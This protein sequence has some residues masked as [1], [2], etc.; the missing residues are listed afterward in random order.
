MHTF[1]ITIQRQSD[2][3]YPVIAEEHQDGGQLPIRV[4]G[5]L[6][7]DQSELL[8]AEIDRVGYGKLL[9]AA[10]F[11]GDVRDGFVE[12]LA[13]A[14]DLLR[15]LLFIEDVPMRAVR[16]ER[17]Y[18]PIDG[19]WKLLATLQRAPFSRYMPSLTDRRFPPIGRRDLRALIVAASPAPDNRFQLEPFDVTAATA[20]VREALGPIPSTLLA[21]IDGADGRPTLDEICAR[22]TA[23]PHTILHLVCHGRVLKDGESVLY[24]AGDA[25]PGTVEPVTGTRLLERL[26]SLEGARGLPHFAFLSTCE[27]ASPD[28][29]EAMGGLG[30][31]LVRELGMPAVVAMTDKVSILTANALSAAIYARLREHGEPDRALVE[32]SVRL[33][34][35]GDVMVPVLF[36]RLGGQPLFSDTLDRALTAAEMAA[37]LDSL[38]SC[39]PVRAPVLADEFGS[40]AAGLRRTLATRPELM[41]DQVRHQQAEALAMIE[42][43]CGEA[44][45]ISFQ[46]LCL[47]QELPPYDARCPFPGLRAFQAD[48]RDFFF[49]REPLVARLLARVADSPFL[50]VL[51]PSGSGKSSAVFAGLVPALQARRPELPLLTM[52]PGE[53]PLASLLA[54]LEQAGPAPTS[55]G[56]PPV[57]RAILVIDQFEEV[58]TL[59]QDADE[60][61]EFF[62]E[63]LRQVGPL[64]VI[65]TLRADFL[66]EVAPYPTL[67]EM[68]TAHQELIAPMTPEELRRAMERQAAA[69]GLRFEA[70]LGGQILDDVRGEP[71]AMPLLQH[72]LQELWA[73]RR[74][75]W[76]RGAEYRAIGGIQQA[77]AH[78]ADQIFDKAP[79]E[80]KERLRAIFVRLTR[81][82]SERAEGEQRD[83]RQRVAIAELVPAGADPA[84]TR[85]LVGL[86]A[87]ARLLVTGV[88]PGGEETAEVAHEA[89]IRGWPRLRA[90]L[91]DDRQGLLL[92]EAI[93]SAAREWAAS[94][95][96]E[97]FLFRGARLDEALSL[98]ALSRFALNAQ[99]QQFLDAAAALRGR[100]AAERE[101]SRQRELQAARELADEQ[102]RRADEAAAA[103]TRQRQLSRFMTG[104]AAVAGAAAIAALGFWGQANYQQGRSDLNAQQAQ[105]AA[106]EAQAQ[107][108]TAEVANELAQAQKATAE[109]ANELAQAQ[110]ATAEVASELA[111]DNALEAAAQAAMSAGNLS[112]AITLDRELVARGPKDNTALQTLSQV[113]YA[114]GVRAQISLDPNVFTLEVSAFALSPDGKLA[115]IGSYNGA[116]GVWNLGDGS[117]ASITMGS[118]DDA[119]IALAYSPDGSS[120]AVGRSQSGVRI[121]GLGSERS[122]GATRG[123]ERATILAYSPDSELLAVVGENNRITLWETASLSVSSQIDSRG[124]V[125]SV[126]FSPNAAELLTGGFDG[127]AT[128]WDVNSG[129]EI[130]R[131]DGGLNGGSRTEGGSR[132]RHTDQVVSVAFSPDGNLAITGSSDK[133][134]GLWDVARRDP[135]ALGF[136]SGHTASVS[137][138]EFSDDS[139]QIISASDDGTVRLWSLLGQQEQQR[140]EAHNTGVLSAL[141]RPGSGNAQAI[142]VGY[143]YTL[144]LWDLVDG[145]EVD[146]FYA[147]GSIDMVALSDDGSLALFA[148]TEGVGSISLS[149]RQPLQRITIN[150][151]AQ[152]AVAALSADGNLAAIGG[153][154]GAITLWNPRSGETL[155]EL[156]GHTDQILSLAFN[157]AGTQLASGSF[158]QTLRIWD[159]ASQS[160]EQ[161][162]NLTDPNDPNIPVTLDAVAWSPDN[163]TLLLGTNDGPW[164]W[165]VAQSAAQIGDTWP[166]GMVLTVAWSPDG[167]TFVV[168]GTDRVV[169]VIDASSQEILNTFTHRGPVQGVAF[170]ADGTQVISAAADRRIS[171]WGLDTDTEVQNIDVTD[172]TISSLAIDRSSGN[173]LT[174]SDSGAARI[175]RFDSLDGLLDWVAANRYAPELSDELQ[176]EIGL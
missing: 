24:L 18:A 171:L 138:V 114:P 59:C 30:Q 52:T 92:H 145:R 174:G 57:A 121:Q 65:I 135:A 125:S 152:P 6:R 77:I 130:V 133:T 165:D 73:R 5:E 21:D 70:D 113:A 80:D 53:L 123:G 69:V 117:Q 67:R 170:S 110:Q 1:E 134:I 36:S 32:G 144:R 153:Q 95:Q 112:L 175:W 81:L 51:G 48:L 107:K 75:A 23:D 161:T 84:P 100:E 46:S 103:A 124:P 158:D 108:A 168:G 88:G 99:E 43:I 93:H 78:S 156:D 38:A 40:A 85:A 7:I 35:R 61:R 47:G 56:G 34:E 176:Q 66:G 98:S 140:L 58:F 29:D 146:R 162:I 15:I 167:S 163:S 63:L 127:A 157:Q 16:W 91:T 64:L 151:P 105:T 28:A 149:T 55:D 37:G 79:P 54:T 136:L 116:L 132:V 90:W 131:F 86:L 120:L 12:A 11:S 129:A 173:I 97:A 109:V 10:L 102:Q 119:I 26:G 76:L 2:G 62:D 14:D 42:T 44:T 96:D 39:I 22:I 137:S 94:G 118:A 128:L 8:A 74:G 101:A 155:G 71:G 19:G 89:L 13:R 17:L 115:A 169:T 111:T 159:V 33:A 141:F 20:G 148:S 3:V 25:G 172:G 50:A 166:I 160:L 9:G 60:R 147:T 31:R 27:S 82:D 142:S 72:A 4:E 83:T 49:G 143:D 164:L 41:D 139:Q 106:V 150:G 104:I 154:S 87:D 122:L 45:G 126:A 68:V